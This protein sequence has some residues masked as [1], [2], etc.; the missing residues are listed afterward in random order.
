MITA[1]EIDARTAALADVLGP[2]PRGAALGYARRRPGNT[3]Q[4]LSLLERTPDGSPADFRAGIDAVAAYGRWLV[5]YARVMRDKPADPPRMV[6]R[7][8]F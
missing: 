5:E 6:P 1:A 7:T 3:E 2:M 8:K 4:L